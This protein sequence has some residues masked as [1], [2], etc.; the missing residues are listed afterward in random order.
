MV[1]SELSLRDWFAGQAI[2]HLLQDYGDEGAAVAAFNVADAMM[3]ERGKRITDGS[4]NQDSASVGQPVGRGAIAGH[5]PAG[6]NA[7]DALGEMVSGISDSRD[8]REEKEGP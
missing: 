4:E 8:Y 7:V 1:E 6:F 5:D 2:G 3:T